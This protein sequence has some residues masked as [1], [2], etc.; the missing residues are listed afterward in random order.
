MAVIIMM[1]NGG[2]WTGLSRSSYG[3]EPPNGNEAAIIALIVLLLVVV[4]VGAVV[5][6]KSA[7]P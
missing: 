7:N 6:F 1:A 5:A 4:I 3:S 2:R